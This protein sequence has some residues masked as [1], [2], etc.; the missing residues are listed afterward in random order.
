[1]ISNF[2]VLSR[3]ASTSQEAHTH[4]NGPE[5]VEFKS[6]LFARVDAAAKP[7]V[8]IASSSSGLPSS[9]FISECKNDPSRILIGHPFNPPHLVPLVEVVPH[10][11]TSESSIVTALDFY[12]SMGKSPIR[13]NIEVPGFLA[14]RMQ[15]AVLME[16]YSLVSRGVASA[17][18][19]DTAMT[20]GLGLRWALTGPYMTNILGGGGG[21]DG[22][23]KMLTKLGP[24]IAS[25]AKDMEEH[26]Y[27]ASEGNFEKLN[28]SVK[29]FVR[30]TDLEKL[31]KERDDLLLQLIAMKQS[32]KNLN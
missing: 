5:N 32:A 7:G 6:K 17:Q 2:P 19:V 12:K 1:M 13:L 3:L 25:W 18:D 11:N 21:S 14:N 15:A 23:E 20:T 9:S 4:Q 8:I 30:E 27:V 31:E 10:P 26:K 24:A 28:N 16:A 29:E 22:F